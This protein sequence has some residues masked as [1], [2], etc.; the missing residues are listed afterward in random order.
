MLPGERISEIHQGFGVEQ[1]EAEATVDHQSRSVPL[2]ARVVGQRIEFG[3]PDHD[4]LQIPPGEI[5]AEWTK[6]E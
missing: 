1:A 6:K 4:V 3:G 5:R 2:P